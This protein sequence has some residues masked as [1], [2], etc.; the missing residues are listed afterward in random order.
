M[1]D[2][3]AFDPV[4][5]KQFEKEGYSRVAEG[6][7]FLS[8]KT[9][10]Q[11]NQPMLDAVGA[12]AGTSLLD[13]A[14]G[15]G[16]LSADA[17]ERGTQVFGLDISDN[18]L[19]VAKAMAEAYRVLK[20]G[21]RYAISCWLPPERNPFMALIL[22][23]IQEHGTMDVDLPPGP[24][25]FRFGEAAE[26]EKVMSEA[27]FVKEATQEIPVLWLIDSPEK[28]IENIRSGTA[29]L[30]PLLLLQTEEARRKIE[31]AIIEKSILSWRSY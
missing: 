11:T 23:T 8:A 24:P 14:C 18:M 10:S 17:A 27:G 29:R 21:G 19:A 12:G 13:I 22:G 15:P 26:C 2:S 25:L 16:R 9:T 20:P 7:N 31:E 6:Y 3:P 1:A 28:I 5:F 30:G 4:S